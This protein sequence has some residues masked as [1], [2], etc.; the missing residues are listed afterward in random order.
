MV[1]ERFFN[2]VADDVK[3][4]VM[5]THHL[6]DVYN[7]KNDFLKYTFKRLS[8]IL[9]AGVV[10]KVNHILISDDTAIVE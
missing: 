2:K 4:T 8:R 1:T 7:S 9:K 5:G 10:L 6:G 3:W